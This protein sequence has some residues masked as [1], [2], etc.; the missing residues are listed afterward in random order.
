MNFLPLPLSLSPN[1]R[2][3]EIRLISIKLIVLFSC[4]AK[5]LAAE[6]LVSEHDGKM[7]QFF[8]V[9]V[10]EDFIIVKLSWT[11]E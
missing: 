9:V 6:M 7:T 11:I 8:F 1:T 10:V 2:C 5:T 3:Q 4:E